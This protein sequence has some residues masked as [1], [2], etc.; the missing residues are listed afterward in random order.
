MPKILSQR[1]TDGEVKVVEKGSQPVY[2]IIRWQATME[3]IT[4]RWES[5]SLS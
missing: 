1:L 2:D 4:R 5:E 3:T